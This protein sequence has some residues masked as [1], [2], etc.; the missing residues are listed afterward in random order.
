MI[1]DLFQMA[2]WFILHLIW[3]IVFFIYIY[4]FIY[5]SMMQNNNNRIFLSLSLSLSLS[6]LQY[7]NTTRRIS[8]DVV[9]YSYVVRV[10]R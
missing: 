10:V 9:S 6:L 5:I 8:I 4:L 1:Y 7:V 3:R 2:V